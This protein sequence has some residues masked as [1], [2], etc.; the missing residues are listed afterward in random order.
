V[1]AAAA[2]SSVSPAVA[3]AAAATAS[4]PLPLPSKKQPQPPPDPRKL[5]PPSWPEVT[6]D[7]LV[8]YPRRALRAQS[9]FDI[10][11]IRAIKPVTLVC[12]GIGVP[13]FPE[14]ENDVIVRLAL[15]RTK[16]QLYHPTD[17]L[18]T[19]R[20]AKPFLQKEILRRCVLHNLSTAGAREEATHHELRCTFVRQKESLLKGVAAVLPKPG[21]YTIAQCTDW[22]RANP[23]PPDERAFVLQCGRQWRQQ[24]R[25]Q[26]KRVE[27]KTKEILT[28][29][30]V[31]AQMEKEEEEAFK[32]SARAAAAR[33]EAAKMA[34]TPQRAPAPATVPALPTIPTPTHP[35]VYTM[36]LPSA[37]SYPTHHPHHHAPPPN[38][39]VANIATNTTGNHLNAAFENYTNYLSASGVSSYSAPAPAPGTAMTYHNQQLAQAVSMN[40]FQAQAISQYQKQLA[41]LQTQMAASSKGTQFEIRV[42]KDTFKFNASHFVAYPGF[43]ERLHGHN[44]RT[45][46]KLIGTDKIGRDGYV[47][48]FGCVKTVTKEVCKELNEYFL[49]PTL[50]EV[51]K[52]TVED[53]DGTET[54]ICGDA[55]D[56]PTPVTKR[57]KK[58]KRSKYPGSVTIETEDGQTFVFPRDDCL[59]LPIAH[60]TAEELAVYIYGKILEKLD[61]DYLRKRGV[62]AMEVTVSEAPGQDAVFRNVIPEAAENNGTAAAKFDVAKF[63]TDDPLPP[64]PCGTDTEAAKRRRIV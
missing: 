56:H 28:A 58:R 50:S 27:P 48:D 17:V 64:M 35:S 41:A 16:F 5:P 22:L 45:S 49:V 31:M 2:G 46:V 54:T 20:Q 9:F 15:K 1:D 53:D 52:I 55:D 61:A 34:A 24:V 10:Q 43:R 18:A 26:I 36:P 47:L 25:E 7:Q 30:E 60:S 3:A 39:A 40:N 57:S 44:Y 42:S 33:A 32:T 59:L 14:L 8:N 4:A 37:R 62:S 51:L 23:L 13:N 19:T 38:P 12:M 6:F 29:L 63:I 11:Q 21:G